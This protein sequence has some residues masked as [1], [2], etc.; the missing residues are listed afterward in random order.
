MDR[1][2]RAPGCTTPIKTFYRNSCSSAMHALD[3]T[4]DITDCTTLVGPEGYKL[5]PIPSI[6]PQP[7]VVDDKQPEN[8]G[9]TGC[10]NVLSR[11]G[12]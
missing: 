4:T 12:W 6:A 1:I 3:T 10:E 11:R 8:S 5:T 2:L 9:R 7:K